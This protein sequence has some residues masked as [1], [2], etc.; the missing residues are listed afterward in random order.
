[1]PTGAD[2][3]DFVVRLLEQPADL[4]REVRDQCERAKRFFREAI[5]AGADFFMLT[6]DFGFNNAPFVSPKHFSEFIAPYL[7]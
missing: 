5:D 2:I 6:C 4:H 3:M 7:T 1:M